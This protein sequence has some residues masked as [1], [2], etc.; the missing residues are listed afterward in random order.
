MIRIR[1]TMTA[2]AAF[3][4][5]LA[6]ALSGASPAAAADDSWQ[7]GTRTSGP[8][9][10][11]GCVGSGLKARVCFDPT[12]DKI[13]VY[14]GDADSASAVADWENYKYWTDNSVY[15]SGQCVNSEGAD[16]WVVC[17]KNFYE[18]GLI[19]LIARTYDRSAG[20]WTGSYG[21]QGFYTS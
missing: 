11:A 21:S 8:S 14:D 18:E 13:Y 7:Q 2:G 1:T 5:A 16:T 3:V 6:L 20:E 17:N 4:G 19:L 12:G 9:G 15:R 10:A